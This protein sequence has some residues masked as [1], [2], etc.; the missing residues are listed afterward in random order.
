M[1]KQLNDKKKSIIISIFAV[2]VIIFC[3]FRYMNANGIILMAP[4]GSNFEINPST[5][6]GMGDFLAY[7]V[8]SNNL[9]NGAD[10]YNR[11]NSY[12]N[13]TDLGLA[14]KNIRP[15]VYP[16]VLAI[17]LI[18]FTYLDYQ[19][20]EFV[21][22]V[23]NQ[24]LLVLVFILLLKI[25]KLEFN[26][27]NSAVLVF[28]ITNFYPIFDALDWGQAGILVF[29]CILGSYYFFMKKSDVLASFLLALAV[30][31]KV[32]PILLLLF[33]LWK[34]EYRFAAYTVIS[35]AILLLISLYF[36]GIASFVNYVSSL[37]SGIIQ[38]QIAFFHNQS[39]H[40]FFARIFTNNY[41]STP[42]VNNNLLYKF[43]AYFASLLFLVAA[44]FVSRKPISRKSP[45]FNLELSLFI[46]LSL[47]ISAIS[48]EHHF[49]IMLFAY[50]ALFFWFVN[51]KTSIY[52]WLLT[53]I[54][55][56][57]IAIQ[58]YYWAPIFHQGILL[59]VT[60][61]KLYAAVLLF[62]VIAYILILIDKK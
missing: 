16:P 51:K 1:K 43:S 6:E 26:L 2:L 27:I 36:T 9:K 30:G 38:P 31:I 40:G 32:A 52:I 12:N 45:R 34:R 33:F 21:W 28:L 18:P 60:G 39:F 56:A 58:S 49:T 29:A 50:V 19:I 44:L 23:C 13:A 22:F 48:W 37:Y 14:G 62:I 47:L 46:I 24:I 55:F 53:F 4:V 35:G 11:T 8:A 42:F 41:W 5:E 15:Y 20:A 7:Y 57:V 25:F 59:L 54:S 10:S 17:I 3:L 61:I